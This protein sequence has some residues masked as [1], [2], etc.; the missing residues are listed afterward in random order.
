MKKK[1]ARLDPFSDRIREI[2]TGS[3]TGKDNV[4]FR[5]KIVAEV[6]NFSREVQNSDDMPQ[7]FTRLCD[8]LVDC[9][10]AGLPNDSFKLLVVQLLYETSYS[11]PPADRELQTLTGLDKTG[12]EAAQEHLKE[13]CVASILLKGTAKGRK[14]EGEVRAELR[15]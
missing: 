7:L 12:I 13:E 9:R 1:Q 11:E 10:S 5:E 3:S 4:K 6:R 15:A 14:K 8:L 2:L